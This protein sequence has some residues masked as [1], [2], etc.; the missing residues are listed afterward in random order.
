MTTN[1]RFKMVRERLE[2]QEFDKAN[3]ILTEL[4]DVCLYEPD[5]WWLV[6]VCHGEQGNHDA[7]ISALES[8]TTYCPLDVQSQ[9][10]LGKLYADKG[11]RE[12]AVAIFSYLAES[13]E[14]LAQH[15]AEIIRQL[16]RLKCYELAVQL[17][18]QAT[19]ESPD[20]W[21]VWF[22]KAFYLGRSGEPDV[23]IVEALQRA[24]TLKPDQLAVRVSLVKTLGALGLEAETRRVAAEIPVAQIKRIC[25]AECICQLAKIYR[26]SKDLPRWQ[27]CIQRYAD[28]RRGK[29]NA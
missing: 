2:Q 1:Q 3:E 21:Q 26:S 15:R 27:A 9:V 20:D 25:C 29:K 19:E 8:A 12:S 18:R 17:C 14:A 7:A 5:Y 24:L 16:G 10:L 28:L 4:Q 22:A 23:R 11:Y 6:A 13:T